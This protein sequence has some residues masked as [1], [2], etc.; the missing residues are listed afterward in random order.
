MEPGY[1]TKAVKA[2]LFSYL[3]KEREIG[4]QIERYEMLKA[5]MEA[6]GTQSLSDMPKA[7]ENKD[8]MAEYLARKEELEG[9][10]SKAMASQRKT[11]NE[12]ERVLAG[13]RNAREKTCIRMR[14]L[15]GS[16]WS[17]VI[18]VLFGEGSC[19]SERYTTLY[20]KVHRV[21]KS[22]LLDMAKVMDL[23]K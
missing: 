13:V 15:D 16:S 9:I 6:P 12:I 8:R 22:A 5:K 19:S 4:M 3:E 21:H 2:W 11:A 10:I 7:H 20:R 1:D 18:E 14:Y 17:E 23:V